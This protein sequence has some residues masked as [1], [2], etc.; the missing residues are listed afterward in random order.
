MFTKNPSKHPIVFMKDVS[1]RDLEA[2]LD[3]MY[4]GEVNVPQS[5]LGSLIKTAE[6]L[7]IKG[8]AVPD[9]PPA[10]RDRDKRDSKPEEPLSPPPKRSRVRENSPVHSL[11]SRSL[12]QSSYTPTPSSSSINRPRSPLPPSNTSSGASQ[13]PVE[14]TL[15][16]DSRTSIQSGVSGLSEHN[17]STTPSL[18]SKIGSSSQQI[19]SNIG[20]NSS[21]LERS[22]NEEPSPG[23]SGI[24][25]PQ[26]KEEPVEIKQEDIV[27]LGEDDDGDWGAEGDAGGG[28]SSMGSEHPPSFPDV[29]L[30]HGSDAMQ[31]T[32][33]PAMFLG[34]LGSLAAPSLPSMGSHTPSM[35]HVA[36]TASHQRIS[37][38]FGNL[39]AAAA[40]SRLPQASSVSSSPLLTAAVVAAAASVKSPPGFHHHIGRGR[41]RQDSIRAQIQQ[42]QTELKSL[43][44]LVNIGMI[45]SQEKEKLD[46]KVMSK[47][48]EVLRLQKELER[49]VSG[50]LRQRKFREKMRK[51]LNESN[52]KSPDGG[53]QNVHFGMLEH[54]GEVDENNLRSPESGS[55]NISFG[56]VE[57]EGEMVPQSV[58]WGTEDE[59]E[60]NEQKNH[61]KGNFSEEE[62]DYGV[63]FHT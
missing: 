12:A 35:A 53:F 47:K 10:K 1:T 37:S 58:V 31:H 19:Q 11:P 42:L 60:E 45:G 49:L 41:Y 20:D 30:P 8:L 6:G 17:S 39:A 44:N 7:Q 62:I 25:K 46:I 40:R 54:G 21:R 57:Q 48:T 43:E 22:G 14:A 9:D 3:F 63:D 24:Q 51:K 34:P 33:D 26:S 15:D 56:L 16:E 23:P 32:G 38:L 28:D 29:V 59:E 55:Q 13:A 36:L 50:Q 4:N 52:M 61:E 27:D 2:L 5:S 18:S